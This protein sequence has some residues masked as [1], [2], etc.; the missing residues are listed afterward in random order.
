MLTRSARRAKM[1]GS[2]GSNTESNGTGVVAFPQQPSMNTEGDAVRVQVEEQAEDARLYLD[3]DG[4]VVVAVQPGLLS[5][6]AERVIGKVLA[7]LGEYFGEVPPYP[8]ELVSR[9]PLH[10]TL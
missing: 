9:E 2:R 1:S 7:L 3:D 4:Q 8:V 10:Q 5:E 6:K